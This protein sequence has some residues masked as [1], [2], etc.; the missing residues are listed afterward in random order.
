MENST[1][2]QCF[3]CGSKM[4]YFEGAFSLDGQSVLYLVCENCLHEILNEKVIEN[5]LLSKNGATIH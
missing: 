5:M 4:L 3:F 1:P 2:E